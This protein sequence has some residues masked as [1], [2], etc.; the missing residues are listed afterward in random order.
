MISFKSE[1]RPRILAALF[2]S[3]KRQG[4]GLL[5]PASSM[6]VE[7]ASDLLERSSYFDYLK[8]HVMK[9]DLKGESF[10][11]WL[12]DR[13]NGEGAARSA[14]LKAGIEIG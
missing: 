5:D 13:D 14:L 1:D 8:G 6:T 4:L 7:E 2:N 9:V 11:P 3:S 10:D 12:Y